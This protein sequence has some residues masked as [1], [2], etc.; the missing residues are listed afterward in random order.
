MSEGF[1]K[2]KSIRYL[3]SKRKL[4]DTICRV[5]S[6]N[7]TRGSTILDMFAGTNCVSYGLSKYFRV[8]SNDVQVLSYVIAR[9][10]LMNRNRVSVSEAREDLEQEYWKNY[11]FLARNNEHALDKEERL[12]NLQVDR[13]KEYANFCSSFQPMVKSESHSRQAEKYSM[14]QSR[15]VDFPFDLF[16]NYF[17]NSYFGLKQ[18]LEIDSL[19]FAIDK[20][21]PTEQTKKYLYLCALIYSVDSCVASPGHFAQFFTPHSK[22]SFGMIIRERRKDV[23]TIFYSLIEYFWKNLSNPH[24]EHEA[25]CTNYVSLFD[26]GTEF[27]SKMKEVD[28]IYADPP[29]TADHYSR[30]YHVLETLTKYDYPEVK[31]KGRYRGD[32]FVSNFSLKS[33][34]Y[35]EFERLFSL[36]SS[37]G[38]KLLLSYNND[39]LICSE[40]LIKL[41]K[42]YFAM[43]QHGDIEYNHSNQG[44]KNT[45][46]QRRRNP[47]RECLVY[48]EN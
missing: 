30:F 26:A 10:L 21:L 28:L 17:S 23:R 35:S 2:I 25:W 22:E 29:Y 15:Q 27:F 32:R 44:R 13:F 19:R 37:L 12:I 8:F 46:C 47:R 1:L 39:G 5:I 34:A 11:D 40:R 31:G 18:C 9:A 42:N 7:V 4:V 43:V 33:K 36:V 3:G 6:D 41:A 45:D 38:C 14:C 20:L 24:F 48:C 16:T